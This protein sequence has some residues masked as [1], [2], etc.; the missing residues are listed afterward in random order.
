[1][2]TTKDEKLDVAYVRLRNGKVAKT[3]EIKPGILLDIDSS[4]E[5]LGIEVL[6][7]SKL[8]PSLI[9]ERRKKKKT[10]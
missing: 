8:A 10:A 5:V 7:V 9:A 3:V 4:G 2:E 6:S 1:M